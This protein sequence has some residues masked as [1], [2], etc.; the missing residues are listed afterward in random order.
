[1]LEVQARSVRALYSLANRYDGQTVVVVSHAD[2]IRA[3]LVVL[4]GMP[5][6]QLIRL[7]ADPSSVWTVALGT[8][9]VV[10]AGTHH[11]E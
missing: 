1:M 10:V 9:Q 5:L 7:R 4:L 11:I 8:D 3:A 6:E 2:V